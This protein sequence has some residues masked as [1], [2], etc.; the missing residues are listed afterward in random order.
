MRVYVEDRV[1]VRAGKLDAF[2][3]ALEKALPRT[4]RLGARCFGALTTAG[5]TGRWN[6]VFVYWEMDG[7][8][9]YAGV[10]KSLGGP[11]S[12]CDAA[13]PDWTLRD[14]G[15]SLTM[16]AT[17]HSP[18]LADLV[19]AGVRGGVFLHE[20]IRVLPGQRAAYVQHYIDN[21][22]E[23]TRKA[24]RELCGIW[25][26]QRSANDVL[27]LL[28]IQDWETH[29]QGL[30]YKPDAY[31]ERPWRTS[32]PKVRDDYDLRM[33]VPGPLAVNPLAR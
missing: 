21:Y 22:L 4:G 7:W 6:E 28:A 10:M 18:A 29:A 27:I 23:A 2:Y 20:Y 14:G 16:E 11:G 9:H 24:G 8:E 1:R 33:L 15:S 12:L 30:E 25:S 32:A 5:A 19:A 3:G 13:D 17:E 31:A 26:L